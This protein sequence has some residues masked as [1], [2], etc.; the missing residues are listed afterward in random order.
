MAKP[1]KFSQ[2]EVARQ[3]DN[4]FIAM[5]QKIGFNPS[6]EE[7]TKLANAEG[8]G[9]VLFVAGGVSITFRNLLQGYGKTLASTVK[10]KNE[11]ELRDL[12][13]TFRKEQEEM[14]TVIRKAM[15]LAQTSLPRR[16]GPGRQPKLTSSQAS[17]MCDQIALCMRQG[18]NLK[19]AL[20]KVSQLAP[21]LLLG[22]K[23]S[24]RTLQKA[25]NQRGQIAPKSNL[26]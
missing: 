15:K 11:E 5:R 6:P 25:W 8:A 21:Q 22:K 18:G 12:I 10:I 24:P 2:A 14:S 26:S 3:L 23:V 17:Q 4:E 19:Q 7:L 16:G 1:K 13:R 9:S 20:Q